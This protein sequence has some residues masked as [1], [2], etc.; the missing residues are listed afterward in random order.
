MLSALQPAVKVNEKY[1]FDSFEYS[2]WFELI[3]TPFTFSCVLVDMFNRMFIDACHLPDILRM[4]HEMW[5][6][7]TDGEFFHSIT[8]R[9]ALTA[10]SLCNLTFFANPFSSACC[11]FH[12]HWIEF[13]GLH[14]WLENVLILT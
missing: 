7:N 1:Y 10:A 12:R 14:N 6:V 13:A 3:K 9:T 2:E 4:Y 8:S 11:E 5:R